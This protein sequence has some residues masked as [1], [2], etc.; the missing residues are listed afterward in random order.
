MPAVERIKA[1]KAALLKAAKRYGP[2]KPSVVVGFN[3]NYAVFVHENTKMKLKGQKRTGKRP[4]GTF[5]EG[6]YWDPQGRGQSKFLEQ[7]ARE[8]QSELGNIIATVTKKTKS[9]EE[10]LVIA[11]LRLQA[12]SQKLVPTDSTNLK[13]SAFLGVEKGGSLNLVSGKIG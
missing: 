2:A 13:G 6:K 11:G 9:L 4:D 1:V 5:R 8:L 12:A 10:G 3:A 7:P